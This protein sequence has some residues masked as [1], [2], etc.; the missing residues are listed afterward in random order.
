ALSGQ[1]EVGNATAAEGDGD[2]V[3]LEA[4]DNYVHAE[5]L[6][7]LA[8]VSGLTVVQT[9]DALLVC[10]SQR[11]D[12][13]RDAVSE[14]EAR[15]RSEAREPARVHRPWGTYETIDRG[16]RF[17]VKRIVV[18]PGAML[19][20]QRHAH[21]AE[22]WVVV[23]GTG[24]ITIGDE[25]RILEENASVFIPIGTVHRLA[26]PGREPLELIEV[27]SGRYLGEDDIE[28]FEDIYSRVEAA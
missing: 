22:H 9:R 16:E 20:L 19:S 2:V 24:R 27:Q 6:V 10:D 13:L 11:P 28:R 12:L 14:L 8:G 3:L 5:T 25:T 15:G 17:Q 7:C 18:K 26:N 1:D 23:R 4:T 21:R